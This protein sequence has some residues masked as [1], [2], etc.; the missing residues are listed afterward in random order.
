M[1]PVWSTGLRATASRVQISPPPH[2]V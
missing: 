2:R 1:A